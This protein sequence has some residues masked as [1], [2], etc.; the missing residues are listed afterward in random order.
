MNNGYDNFNVCNELERLLSCFKSQDEK[1]KGMRPQSILIYGRD[2]LGKTSLVDERIKFA[3]LE[4][5]KVNSTLLGGNTSLIDMLKD[6]ENAGI[7]RTGQVIVI[8]D[9]EQLL[10]AKDAESNSETFIEIRRFISNMADKGNLVIAI[11]NAWPYYPTYISRIW[12]FEYQ[13]E[14]PWMRGRTPLWI[15]QEFWKDKLEDGVDEGAIA[16]VFSGLS[17][18][19]LEKI[20]KKKCLYEIG[21]SEPYE[22]RRILNAAVEVLFGIPYMLSEAPADISDGRFEGAV[23]EAGKI[24]VSEITNPGSIRISTIHRLPGTCGGRTHRYQSY[25]VYPTMKQ[26]EDEVMYLLAGKAAIDVVYGLIDSACKDDLELAAQIVYDCESR[27]CP[28]DFDVYPTDKPSS[29]MQEMIESAVSATLKTLYEK[30]CKLIKDNRSFLDA[31]VY[32][33]ANSY[34]VTQLEISRLYI[35]S[36]KK[37]RWFLRMMEG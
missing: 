26:N 31:I 16:S 10:S 32:H 33:L 8:D 37:R 15:S 25:D 28:Y 2:G 9:M 18:G 30:T 13:I 20:Y 27:L 23:Y 24:V 21:N 6:T 3:E 29:N 35:E 36:P 17:M 7:D 14:V 12:S 1:I 4:S 11:V 19:E 5:V 34:T 22:Y